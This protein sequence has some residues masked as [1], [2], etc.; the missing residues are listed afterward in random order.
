MLGLAFVMVL[1]C[2]VASI[3]H[4]ATSYEALDGEHLVLAGTVEWKEYRKVSG[5]KQLTVSLEHVM[6]LKPEKASLLEQIMSDSDTYFKETIFANADPAKDRELYQEICL[7]E[8]EGINGVICYL[9]ETAAEAK[10]IPQMGSLLLVEGDFLCMSHATN[11]G[12]FDMAEYYQ[13]LGQQGRLMQGVILCQ[14]KEQD[15]FR[16]SLYRI[17]EY[18]GLLLDACYPEKEAAVMRAMLLGEKGLLD[19]ELKSL[20]QQNGIIH[21]LSISGLHLSVI[22]MG[23]YKLLRKLRLPG[24]AAAPLAVGFMFCY[25]TMTGMGVSIVRAFVMFTFHM[26]AELLGRTYDLLT[27]LT[28]SAVI[29]LMGQPLYLLHSGFLFSF[30]AVCGIGTLLPAAMD[31]LLWDHKLCHTVL[32]GVMVSVSTLPVYLFYYYEFPPYSILLNLMVIPCM[33]LVLVSGLLTLCGS[34]LWLPLGQFPALVGRLL[35][36]LYE[37]SCEIC[38][39]LPGHQMITGCPAKWQIGMFLILL[40]LM[41]LQ[42]GKLPKLLFWQGMLLALA[43]LTFHP[44]GGLEIHMLDVGQ[45]D[46]ICIT[47]GEESILIDGGS[48][49]Q[50]DVDVYRIVPFLKYQGISELKAVLVT[51]P[52]SDHMNGIQ[53]MLERYQTNGIRIGML[54][55]PSVRQECKNEQYSRLEELAAEN[56]IPVHYLSA[57]ESFRLGKAELVCLHP[58][59]LSSYTDANEMSVVLWM[60]YGEF[61]AMFTGDLEGEGESALLSYLQTGQTGSAECTLPYGEGKEVTLLKVA[62]HGSMGATSQAFLE[63]IQPRVALISSGRDNR[64]GHP[65]EETLERLQTVGAQLLGT[66]ECGEISV[67]YRSGSVRV[68]SFLADGF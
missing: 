2:I 32:S 24:K 26:T 16:E 9:Q 1:S 59:K 58:E 15:V 31:N 54:L 57:G 47:E 3:P 37:K 7:E 63:Q 49:D 28:V 13:I 45:G 35:L 62:H 18:C 60:Q 52:D 5:E 67:S 65:H 14:G 44:A 50:K 8:T 12:E 20:Y 38:N 22:G 41:I 43:V 34:C 4:R 64:Y 6:V 27:A 53:G 48:T 46:C 61:T 25:G 21:I 23:F 68:R 56:E 40:V 42:S 51:H 39:A 10:E 30:G 17:R 55:L 33:S 19:R 29:L 36:L 66:Q 11:P